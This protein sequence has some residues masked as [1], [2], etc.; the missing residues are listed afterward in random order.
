M[1]TKRPI[2]NCIKMKNKFYLHK[3]LLNL[4][5]QMN[6]LCAETLSERHIDEATNTLLDAFLTR[7]EPEAY[8]LQPYKETFKFR[9]S[10]FVERTCKDGLSV[11]M[12]DDNNRNTVAGV[13]IC[14]DL[15][16]EICPKFITELQTRQNTN[17]EQAALWKEKS[18]KLQELQIPLAEHMKQYTKYERV[19][20]IFHIMMLA[21]HKDY[22]N[23]QVGTKLVKACLQTAKEKGYK[24]VF[25]DATSEM[26]Q[27]VYSKNDFKILNQIDYKTWEYPKGSNTYPMK[28]ISDITGFDTHYLLYCIP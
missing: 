28:S 10:Y 9:T 1:L 26:S 22:I 4:Q 3:R 16:D 27:K 6:Q 25:V 18:A 12:V 21:V 17:A 2:M 14:Y 24:Y 7:N 5:F 11:V 13:Q 15:Y 23:Q 20:E 8:K 19:G